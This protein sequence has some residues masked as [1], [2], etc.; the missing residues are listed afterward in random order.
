[1]PVA[2]KTRPTSIS[3]SGSRKRVTISVTLPIRLLQQLKREHGSKFQVHGPENEGSIGI[4]ESAWFKRI[5][6][7]LTPGRALR[8]YRENRGL[9]RADIAASL[10]P[11]TRTTHVA[12]MEAGRRS[13]S[14]ETAKK[15]ARVLNAPVE[16]FL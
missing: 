15:L 11:S 2:E 1:M 12:D 16:R 5:S 10:G 7:E 4:H 3:T 9:S 8:A 14:K 6:A 13:I